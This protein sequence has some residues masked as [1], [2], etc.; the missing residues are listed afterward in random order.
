MKKNDPVYLKQIFL[1][2]I[3]WRFILFFLSIV[4]PHFFKYEPSFPYADSLLPSYHLPQWFYSWANFDGVHYLTI[5][6]KG[7]KGTGLIQAFFPIYPLMVKFINLFFH[8]SLLSGISSSFVFFIAGIY[9][10]FLLLKSKFS[11]KVAWLSL[12]F[13]L[14]FPTSFFFGA[15]YS[16]SLFF[17]LVVL[18][19]YFSNQKNWLYAGIAAGLASGT[20]VVGIF[21]L[22]ALLNDLITTHF[23][24]EV[25]DIKKAI[26]T[27]KLAG[28]HQPITKIYKEVCFTYWK[29]LLAIIISL[30]GLISYMSYLYSEFHDPLYFFHVQSSFGSGRETTLVLLPQV[31]WRGLKILLSAPMDWRWWTYFQEFF[32]TFFAFTLC[33][34][35]FLKRFKI[36]SSWILFSL[37]ALLLP[38]ST[39]TLSSMP[40]YVLVALPVFVI[41]GSLSSEHKLWRLVLLLSSI[42][43]IL[44]TV[45]FIQGYWI[46]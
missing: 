29:E 18:T 46:A 8:N 9:F 34:I 10:F 6:E 25:Q 44:N 39:G 22:P 14:T 40:R 30:V 2:A 41:L 4:A 20:R 15:L 38:T 13:L 24:L 28:I 23:H 45:L 32:F 16:E 7:Y 43:L 11:A 5:I 27:L 37:L 42:G 21:L 12:F 36:P 33:C 17:L 31:L 1:V 19:F 26:L 35:G 3:I